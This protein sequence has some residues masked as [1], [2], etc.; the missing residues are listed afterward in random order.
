MDRYQIQKQL[1]DGTYGSVLLATTVGTGE[2]VAIKRMKKKYY[3]WDDCLNLREVKSLRKLKHA[4]IV[5][6]KEVIR[7]NDQLYFVFEFMK[8]NLYQMTK[9][10]DKLF[11]ESVVRNLTFQILQGLH[12]MHKHGYFHRDM[13][14]ENL[15]CTGHDLVKIADFGLAREVRSRPPYTDYVST[16]WYRAPEVLLRSTN[17]NSPIDIWAVGCIM[18]ELYTLRPLFPGNSEID[19]IFKICSVLG[20]PTK[21]DWSEGQTLAASMNFRWPQCVATNLKTIIPNASNE[22]LH[23]LRDMLQWDPKKRPTCAQAL[24]Y[25]FFHVGQTLGS[26]TT[27]KPQ[28]SIP[29]SLSKPPP[30][31]E[32]DVILN[33]PTKVAVSRPSNQFN[34]TETKK[35]VVGKENK[36]VLPSIPVQPSQTKPQPKK[37]DMFSQQAQAKKSGGRRKWGQPESW[38]DWDDFEFS[39]TYKRRQPVAAAVP[40]KR[41]SLFDDDDDDLF[42]LKDR[43]ASKVQPVKPRVDSGRSSSSSAK[44]HYLNQAR[45]LPGINPAKASSTKNS[46]PSNWGS[47]MSK[48]TSGLYGRGS[49]T[50]GAAF[51]PGYIP[52]FIGAGSTTKSNYNP[53]GWKRAQAAPIS[54]SK[55]SA[56]IR[57]PV[58]PSSQ[59]AIHGRT[60]WA[61]KYLKS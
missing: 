61:A 45:Y 48:N 40:K 6:L 9:S 49:N 50:V 51:N 30:N 39:P 43:R 4:N 7:E 2:K 24:R 54:L 20:T 35:E 21:A 31:R 14:P 37:D 38:D 29:K 33:A 46:S 25:P 41:D 19:E 56:N 53:G 28:S 5:Q 3:K 58:G 17:Y 55:N 36:K 52:S 34:Q 13:K 27:T 26:A 1:G 16:R 8:E 15:L 42:G 22:G 44:Q 12:Y 10:R 32:Q 18:A 23:L 47:G 59:V 60:D 11:P 57:Q